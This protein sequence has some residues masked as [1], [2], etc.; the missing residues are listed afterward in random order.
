M[1]Y[2][3]VID[4]VTSERYYR[5][6]YNYFDFCLL[7]YQLF[8][9]LQFTLDTL[10]FLIGRLKY[11]ISHVL[12]GRNVS[13]KYKKVFS[14]PCHFTKYGRQYMSLLAIKNVG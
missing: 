10:D 2:Y 14:E 6:V 9:S 4:I 12:Q 11:H 7:T 3:N 1:L 5:D 13:K 8:V